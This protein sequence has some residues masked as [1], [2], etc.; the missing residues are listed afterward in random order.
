LKV[1][2]EGILIF[3]NLTNK[4]VFKNET[5]VK[6]LFN[7]SDIPSLLNDDVDCDTDTEILI[8]IDRLFSVLE[9]N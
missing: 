3:N 8:T 5:A 9:I 1:I 6:L 4:L 7:F 2:P